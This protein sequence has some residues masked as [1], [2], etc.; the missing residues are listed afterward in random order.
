MSYPVVFFREREFFFKKDPDSPAI[1]ILNPRVTFASCMQ[2][3]NGTLFT[4]NIFGGADE[5]G[6]DE[7]GVLLD[8]NIFRDADIDI[9][10]SKRIV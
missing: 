2:C 5:A 7:S 1:K 9:S 8:E 4:M 3:S 10:G 6:S